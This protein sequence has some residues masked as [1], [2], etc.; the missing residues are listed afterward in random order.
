MSKIEEAMNRCLALAQEEDANIKK[1]LDHKAIK[2][3]EEAGEFAAAYLKHVGSKGTNKTPA[4]VFDNL[5]EEG[6][7]VTIVILSILMRYNVTVD[8]I[9]AKMDEK[10]NKWERQIRK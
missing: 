9:A 2:V 3:M 1:T 6:C 8:Q 4:A 5:L 10:M 7:D